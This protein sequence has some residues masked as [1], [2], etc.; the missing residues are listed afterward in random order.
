[1]KAIEFK[2]HCNSEGNRILPYF[3]AKDKPTA[4]ASGHKIIGLPIGDDVYMPTEVLQFTRAELKT[5]NRAAGLMKL[6]DE[7]LVAMSEAECDAA[8][9]AFCDAHGID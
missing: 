1:M 6:V 3:V 2:M 8:T 9:D 7:E 5:R 4:F